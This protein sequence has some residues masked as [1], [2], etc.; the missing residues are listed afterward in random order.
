[1]RRRSSRRA[2]APART[3]RGGFSL[4]EVITSLV[5]LAVIILAL[6]TAALKLLHQSS[7]DTRTTTALQLVQDR[8]A[9]IEAD[10]NYASL[11]A[12]YNA[13]EPNAGGNTGLTR[14]TSIA[15][16]RTRVG[17]KYVDYKRVTVTVSGTG[18]PAPLAR[19][20]TVGAP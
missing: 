3:S 10:P 9:L 4:I 18:L 19:T 17:T 13:T 20:V 1:M 8:F 16:S 2:A 6:Q 15:Q 7:T 11:E 14:T 12:T 5:L